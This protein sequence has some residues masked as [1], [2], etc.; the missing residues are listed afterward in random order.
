MRIIFGIVVEPIN[1]LADAGRRTLTAVAFEAYE[2]APAE[3]EKF[4]SSS[5]GLPEHSKYLFSSVYEKGE[6]EDGEG[7]SAQPSPVNPAVKNSAYRNPPNTSVQ[8]PVHLL[9]KKLQAFQKDDD[10]LLISADASLQC[11][12]LSSTAGGYIAR[13]RQWLAVNV[14]RMQSWQ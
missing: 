14:R 3:F 9:I 8:M 7:D 10:D 5:F 6:A 1:N 12:S 11:A 4:I 13:V 2:E